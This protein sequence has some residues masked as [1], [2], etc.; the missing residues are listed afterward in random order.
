MKNEAL[1]KTNIMISII[2]VIGFMLTA[3]FGYRANYQMSLDNIEQVSSLT[4]EGIYY[5]LTAMFTRPVNI[6][7]TM[8]RD[9]LLVSHM[10]QETKHLKDQDYVRAISNYLETYRDKY[11]FD[12]VFLVSAA[13][14]RYYNFNGVDRVLEPGNPENQWYFDLLNSS[15]EYTLNVDNDEVQWA[16]NEVTVFV[17]CKILDEDGRILGVVGVGI[18]IRYLKELLQS[19]EDKYRLQASLINGQG[20]V[21]ISTTYTG[22]QQVD[23]FD[24]Y[25]QEGIRTQVLGWNEDGKNLELWSTSTEGTGDKSFVVTRYIPELSWHVVIE[26]NT[27]RLV[28]EMRNQ[29]LQTCLLIIAVICTV[30]VV[31]TTVI[32]NFN[33]R[34]TELVEERQAIFKRATEQ[35]YENIY[36]LNITKNCCVGKRTQ[37]YFESLGAGGLPF[38]EGLKIV[39]GKQIKEE[40][41]DGYIT[42]FSPEN[43]LRRYEQGEN[44]LQYDF[45][46]SQDGENY[47]WMRIDA[48]IFFSA[49][50]KCVHMFTYRKNIDEEKKQ[51]LRAALDGMTGFF[52]KTASER[53]IDKLLGEHPEGKFAFFIFDIDN[54]KQANDNFGHGFGDMCIKEFTQVI[55]R[56]FGEENVLG[57][58]GGD[59]FAAFGRI[60]DRE[61]ARRK[62]AELSAAL[63]MVCTGENGFSWHMSASIG[64][65]LFPEDGRDFKTLY[66]HADGALYQTKK[67]GKNG[68]TIY[69]EKEKQGI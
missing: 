51:E 59:E 7:L 57:R 12:S 49:E 42:T 10:E 45:L 67:K 66:R 39:A 48:Y 36:E 61:W 38:D 21:E 8:S 19:Y 33:R 13:T 2:L 1:L 20:G 24:T 50:D 55:R 68:Y 26:Q 53:L 5:Q 63:N 32:R 44:H 25:G 30:L 58:L 56:S 62:A 17:N 18:R 28:R 69:S 29:M 52:S 65:A 64:V 31:I 35:M 11:G 3:V 40:F 23:W 54:F 15:R 46:I 43:V 16:D 47:F 60:P 9:S 6:S 22:Y 14:G 37:E 41:R 34:I 4:A 27:G